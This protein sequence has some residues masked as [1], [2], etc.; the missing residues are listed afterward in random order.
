MT[1]EYQDTAYRSGAIPA[2]PSGGHPDMDKASQ[3]LPWG[4]L[5]EPSCAQHHGDAVGLC[6]PVRG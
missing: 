4:A 2:L 1:D 3:R 5:P 6:P